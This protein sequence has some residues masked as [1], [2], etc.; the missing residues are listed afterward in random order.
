MDLG[1]QYMLSAIALEPVN[2]EYLYALAYFYTQQQRVEEAIGLCK[3]L[4]E[5]Y[6]DDRNVLG[7]VEQLNSI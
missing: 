3:R 4:L 6:P 5:L 2:Y 1:E 7:L